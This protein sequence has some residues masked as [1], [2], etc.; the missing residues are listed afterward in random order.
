MAIEELTTQE[1]R[2]VELA[3]QSKRVGEI[4]DE[5]GISI[6]GMKSLNISLFGKLDL[7][8]YRGSWTEQLKEFG[9]RWSRS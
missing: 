5:L 1:W 3:T 7:P 2:V 9:E 8:P 4:I 6:E